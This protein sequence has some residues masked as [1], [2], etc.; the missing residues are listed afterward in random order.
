[1]VFL[2]VIAV[3]MKAI[4]EDTGIPL[5]ARKLKWQGLGLMEGQAHVYL[6]VRLDFWIELLL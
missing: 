6:P 5:A 1:M 3:N 2:I 4:P